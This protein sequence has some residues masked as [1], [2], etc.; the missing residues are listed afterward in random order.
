MPK[1]ALHDAQM[2]VSVT[3]RSG[4]SRSQGTGWVR[5]HELWLGD[6]CRVRRLPHAAEGNYTE[7]L[8][9]SPTSND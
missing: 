2:I 3:L 4:N 8:N 1:S 9:R 6:R 7:D 5:L